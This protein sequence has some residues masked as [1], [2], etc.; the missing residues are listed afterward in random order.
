[1]TGRYRTAAWVRRPG[2]WL[3]A[4]AA[5]ALGVGSSALAAGTGMLRHSTGSGAAVRCAAP[6]LAGSIVTVTIG[7][8]GGGMGGGMMMGGAGWSGMGRMTIIDSP[9]TVMAGAVSLRVVNSGGLVHEVLVL[10]LPAGQSVGQRP[11]GADGRVD[12]SSSLGEAS[13]SCG[14]GAGDGVEPGTTGWVSLTL[15]PGR[16]E[17]LCNIAGHYS[18]DAYAELD[19]S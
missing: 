12:E 4:A 7:D 14:A 1:M 19:V 11:V 15:A 5:L 18:A 8:M 10:P 3:I 2:V 13:R 6:A 17:L 16:Y 9:R